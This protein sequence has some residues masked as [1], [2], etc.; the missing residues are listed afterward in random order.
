MPIPIILYGVAQTATP[1][2][3]FFLTS[4]QP[5]T[6]LL[7][8]GETTQP[9]SEPLDRKL[10]PRSTNINSKEELDEVASTFNNVMMSSFGTA[11]PEKSIKP[12]RAVEFFTKE[13]RE[14]RKEPRKTYKKAKPGRPDFDAAR[15]L[16]KSQQSSYNRAIKSNQRSILRAARTATANLGNPWLKT[17]I[18]Q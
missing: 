6:K 8:I 13:I 7:K 17:P 1:K 3:R 12:G 2:G 10:L 4:S 16:R 18:V 15:T 14:L 9:L 5:P 11:F